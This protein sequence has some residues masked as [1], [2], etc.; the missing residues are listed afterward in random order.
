LF[1]F[2]SDG[3][4]QEHVLEHFIYNLKVGT[5]CNGSNTCEWKAKL[6]S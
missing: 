4:L 3:T 1:G 6:K 2:L 5:I